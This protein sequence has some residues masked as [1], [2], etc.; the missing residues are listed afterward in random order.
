[1]YFIQAYIINFFVWWY[2]VKAEEVLRWAIH[3]IIYIF[4][5]LNIWPMLSNLFTPMFQDR[6]IVGRF[7]AFPIRL[8]WGF[9]GLFLNIVIA[10]PIILLVLIYFFLPIILLFGSLRFV[11]T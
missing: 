7:V 6:S 3:R 8:I 9:G 10:I 11:L 2:K 4:I 5:L 1:M